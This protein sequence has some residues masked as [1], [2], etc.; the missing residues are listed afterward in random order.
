MAKRQSVE[1]QTGTISMAAVEKALGITVTLARELYEDLTP[2]QQ[3]VA[4][5]MA[6]G[7]TNRQIAAELDIS[8]KT[9]DIHRGDV[10]GK[11]NTGTSAGVARVV[12]L[13]QLAS[14]AR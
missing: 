1:K 9:L 8:P 13:V 14:A 2:R 3:E 10:F 4:K 6:T 7:L 12:H 11:L 5:L